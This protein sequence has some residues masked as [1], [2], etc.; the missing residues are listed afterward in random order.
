MIKNYS[1]EQ[2]ILK[3][4]NLVQKEKALTVYILHHLCE[5]ERRKLE[6][7]RGHSSLYKFCLHELGYSEAEALL[8][9]RAMRLLKS[10]PEAEQ[11]IQSG[12]LSLTNAAEIQNQI[13]RENDRRKKTALPQLTAED[14][15]EVLRL[16]ENSSTRDCQRSLAIVFPE[17]QIEPREQTR[18][19]RDNKT[20]IQFTANQELMEKLEKIKGLL[21]HKNFAGS[22]EQLFLE[23]AN[24]ALKKLDPSQRPAACSQHKKL[25]NLKPELLQQQPHRHENKNQNQNQNQL[26]LNDPM[27]SRNS[28]AGLPTAP[29]EEAFRRNSS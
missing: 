14:K 5:V 2:L 10:I 11:K 26:N 16:T 29:K 6:L 1:D 25:R 19:T 20:L 3:L 4:K 21:A 9:I 18:V 12:V 7:S 13:R 17:I 24:L 15:I 28:N 23:L 8:R 22:Y 27:D